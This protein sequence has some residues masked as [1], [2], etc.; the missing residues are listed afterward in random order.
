MLIYMN[1]VGQ[2]IAKL[3]LAN[4]YKPMVKGYK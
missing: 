1:I 2:H 4:D 3:F